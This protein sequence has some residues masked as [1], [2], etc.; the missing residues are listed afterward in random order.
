MRLQK[1]KIA[2]YARGRRTRT[3]AQI[4][5]QVFIYIL[6]AVIIGLI[7]IVGFRAINTIIQTGKKIN[8]DSFQ[9]DFV[10]SVATTARQYGSVKKFEFTLSDNFEE[11][12]FLDS[13]NENEKFAFSIS[14][15]TNTWIKDSV[16]NDVRMNVFLLNEKEILSSFYVEKL[17][18]RDDY[19]CI[20]NTGKMEVWMKGTG[21]TAD[22]YTQ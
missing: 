19:L 20:K 16:E 17:D 11:I 6:A 14:K 7:A 18:V 3:K 15:V 22:L 10:S 9:N 5:S 1:E 8:I 2:G 21:K 4:S 12:C 13:M